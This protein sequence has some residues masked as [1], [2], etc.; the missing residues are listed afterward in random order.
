M[1]DPASWAL[2][3]GACFTGIGNILATILT[4]QKTAR[5]QKV[6]SEKLERTQNSVTDRLD[7][8]QRDVFS[9][10]ALSHGA[11]EQSRG[12]IQTQISDLAVTTGRIHELA[13]G[14]LSKLN[15]KLEEANEKIA[16]LS[17]LSPNAEVLA[18][19]ND[20]LYQ[21]T[22]ELR[23]VRDRQHD[24]SNYLNAAGLAFSLKPIPSTTIDLDPGTG[25][26]TDASKV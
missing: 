7:R 12:K 9:T 10:L 14:N 6:V 17:G 4:A 15:E 3:V 25:K 22:A 19:I 21:L 2:L 5:E 1:L 23:A 20:K 8:S 24:L 11:D 16:A 18:S 13:D 26:G